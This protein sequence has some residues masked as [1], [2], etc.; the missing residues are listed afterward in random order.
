[1]G[2]RTGFSIALMVAVLVAW[3]YAPAM[4]GGFVYED[5]RSVDACSSTGLQGRLGT[6]ALWC[7]QLA[8]YQSPL[9][10]H[11]LNL[12]L[13]L[14][15][16]GLVLGVVWSFTGQ[17]LPTGLAAAFFG[18]NAVNVE[19]VAYLSSRSELLA[20]IGVL[21]AC[22][23]A[24]QRRWWLVP[25]CLA[26]GWFGKE[27][28]VVALILVP[29]CLWYQRGRPWG[30]VA[31][32]SATVLVYQILERTW[33]WWVDAPDRITWG[34]L[35]ATALARLLVL[36]I[37]PIGQ[38]VDYDYAAVPMALRGFAVVMLLAGLT[39]AVM[40][41]SRLLLCGVAWILC[42]AAPRF[43]VPTP[44]SVFPEHQF[45][46]PLVGVAIMLAS[47]FIQESHD[48]YRTAL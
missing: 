43:I 37:L 4:R 26:L 7:W 27:S 9:A 35:Q 45:Y 17:A 48:D 39:W 23:A 5:Y 21:G 46:L 18:V 8:G 40:Q 31:G 2:I 16:V 14:V 44:R 12:G 3:E 25:I 47:V 22:L 20:A 30:W 13:H 24:L 29:V 11:A 15:V 1:M 19:A 28:A 10:F 38:T 6:R 33:R 36:S 41:R 32:L 34:V 42:A